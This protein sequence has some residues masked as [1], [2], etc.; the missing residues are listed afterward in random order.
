MKFFRE[1]EPGIFIA[2]GRLQTEQDGCDWTAEYTAL[3]AADRPLAVIVNVNDQPDV[4]AG[5]PMVLWMKARKAELGR[6]IRV[7]VYVVDDEAERAELERSLPGR[8]KALPYPA[9]IAASEA[10]A[11]FLARAS[12]I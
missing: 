1:A 8:A 9:A 11:L 12:L 3:L 6:L 2:T 7:T 10:D 5:K 4:A